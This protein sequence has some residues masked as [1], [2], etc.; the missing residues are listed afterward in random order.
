[1]SD[2]TTR[3]ECICNRR[4][5][6]GWTA[7]VGA[8]ALCSVPQVVR[9]L[10]QA[11][12]E[13]GRVKITGVKTARIQTEYPYNLV[14]IETD[15]GLV[16]IGEACPGDDIRP[17]ISALK[18]VLI[19]QDPLPVETN[20]NRMK[21]ATFGFGSMEGSLCSAI[22]GIESALWD[23]AGKILNVPIYVLLGAKYRDKV[24]AYFDTDPPQTSDPSPWRDE[25]LKV[26]AMGYKSIKFDLGW[27]RR[28]Q[29]FVGKP[30]HYRRD[31][32]N[33]S[34]SNEEMNQWVRI[35]EVIRKAVGDN[36]DLAVDCHSEYNTRDGLRFAQSVESLKLLFLE[37]PVAAGNPEAMARITAA[38]KTPIL[39]GEN[40]YGRQGFLPYI[41]QQACDII[42]PDPQKTGGLLETKRIGDLA[43]LYSIPMCFHN[44]G[45]PIGT[46]G[47]AHVAVATRSFL[48]LESRQRREAD[49]RWWSSLVG[50]EGSLY[51]DGCLTL[52][53]GPGLGVELDE[54]VCKAHLMPG[55]RLFE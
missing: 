21:E 28:G 31:M 37:D 39:T 4:G 7:G 23:V 9:A 11:A 29:A 52:P 2:R 25:A 34:V 41:V 8:A 47:S 22:G 53:D 36:I 27:E 18:A 46:L 6:L 13:L 5:L 40:F 33:R 26:V 54:E 19:G 17:H 48:Q 16:G 20:W 32:W 10:P 14:K 35:L 3:A 51:K 45:S 43:D 24:M 49:Y 1:M 12:G 42:Q 15:S 50:R 30:Y 44:L 38:T 55:T